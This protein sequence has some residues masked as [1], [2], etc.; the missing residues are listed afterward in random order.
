M[1]SRKKLID[2]LA[3]TAVLALAGAVARKGTEG[4]WELVAGQEPPR[5]KS[6][7]AVTFGEA[8]AWAL[9][10]GAVVGLARMAVRRGLI[11]RR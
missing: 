10:S 6:N 1:A 9:V 4:T 2:G 5:E 7:R 8:A 3:L 11:Y